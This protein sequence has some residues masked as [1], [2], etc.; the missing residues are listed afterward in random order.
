MGTSKNDKR[1]DTIIDLLGLIIDKNPNIVLDSGELIGV[2][3]SGLG[4][5]RG[6]Y[7]RG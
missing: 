3:D 1:L 7:D 5:L 2:I 4:K 6:R